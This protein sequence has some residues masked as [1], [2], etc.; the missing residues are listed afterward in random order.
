MSRIV[1]KSNDSLNYYPNNNPSDFTVKIPNLS[2]I[3][4]NLKVALSEIIFPFGFKNVREGYNQVDFI[5]ATDEFK[6]YDDDNLIISSNKFH[7]KPDFYNPTSLIDEIN[8]K[9]NNE[10]IKLE[11]E[12]IN[13]R[14]S[15]AINKKKN[16][17]NNKRQVKSA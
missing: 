7:I 6:F 5:L 12:I 10:A 4:H 15:V 17:R 13:N 14:G 8:A 1:L 9:I 2:N 11:L 16:P 3:G